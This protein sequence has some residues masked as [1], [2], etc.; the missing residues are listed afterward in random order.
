[1]PPTPDPAT[2]QALAQARLQAGALETILGQTRRALARAVER[3]RALAVS[4]G[5]ALRAI[6]MA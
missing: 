5:A 1:M 3:D 2:L 4:L 6:G